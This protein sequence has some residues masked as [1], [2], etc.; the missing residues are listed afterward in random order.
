MLRFAAKVPGLGLDVRTVNMDFAYD[1][2][3]VVDS[4]DAYETLILDALLGDASLFT[5]ADEVEAAW[6][7]VTPILTGWAAMPQPH[8]PDY[9]A[10]TWGP[11]A[12]DELM[13]RDGRRWRRI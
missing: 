12:A 6:S 10:G 13:E 7:V 11:E 5:R 3:F 1:T 4:P 2:S 9:A 8:F